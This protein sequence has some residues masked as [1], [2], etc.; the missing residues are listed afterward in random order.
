MLR[1]LQ[2]NIRTMSRSETAIIKGLDDD[3]SPPL[4][5]EPSK[6]EGKYR[7]YHGAATRQQTHQPLC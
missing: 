5:D 2:E 4:W 6:V 7:S 1:K 3:F